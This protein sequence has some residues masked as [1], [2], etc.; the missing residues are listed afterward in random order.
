MGDGSLQDALDVA[1]ANV[2]GLGRGA[3]N[4][5]I[6]QGSWF[7]ALPTHLQGTFDVVV[8]NP[9]YIA[10]DDDEVETGVVNWEPHGALFSGDDGLDAL[11]EIIGQAP[12]WLRSQGWLIVEIGYQQG[13]VVSEL[14]NSAGFEDVRVGNDLTGRD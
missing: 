13:R 3:T 6:A 5:R 8:S 2:T 7:E 11:R 4:V 9:P 14:M 12:L 1:R 10:K